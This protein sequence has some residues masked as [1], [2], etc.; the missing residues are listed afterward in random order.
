MDF[1]RE[2]L[3]PSITFRASRSGGSGG[4][5]V[6]KVSSRVEL[7]FDFEG[8][9]FLS[10]EQKHKLRERLLARVDSAGN[11]RIVSDEDRSQLRNKERAL[12]KLVVLLQNALKEQKVR[13]ASKPGKAAREKRLREKQ[14]QA[15][16]KM[17]RKREF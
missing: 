13:K 7:L 6:N 1:S 14:M 10:D 16:K 11:L 15:M 9:G 3:L 12:E 5:H 4:Q 2:L 17:N 8:A